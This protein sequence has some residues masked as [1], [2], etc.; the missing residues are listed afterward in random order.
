MTG[1]R[2]RAWA[3]ST[4]AGRFE[5]AIQGVIKDAR[6]RANRSSTV[7]S[8]VQ[9]ARPRRTPAAKQRAPVARPESR[10]A[11]ARTQSAIQSASVRY[12]IERKKKTGTAVRTTGVHSAA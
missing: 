5:R 7:L 6:E 12:S 2:S 10:T 1:T 11:I 8:D 4:A 3:R 9:T